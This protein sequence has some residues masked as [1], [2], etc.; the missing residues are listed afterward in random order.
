MGDNDLLF[1]LVK[2]LI[3]AVPQFAEWISGLVNGSDP[4]PDVTARVR[5]ILPA[6]SRSREA[7]ERL[8]AADEEE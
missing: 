5:D 3:M 7:A 6:K 8:E 4:R 1:S 2:A